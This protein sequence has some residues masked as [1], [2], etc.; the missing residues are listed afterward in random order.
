MSTCLRFAPELG[1]CPMQSALRVCAING[2]MR[3]SNCRP[4]TTLS[5]RRVVVCRVRSQQIAKMPLAE[6]RQRGQ[7]IR[8]VERAALDAATL[9]FGDRPNSNY[10][11]AGIMGP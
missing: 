1:H 2:L 9:N 8:R 10:G 6:P 5:A 4:S 11:T 7:D 3:H